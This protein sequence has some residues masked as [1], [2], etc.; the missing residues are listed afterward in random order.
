MIG[1]GYPHGTR[2]APG[3]IAE[4]IVQA[5]L[6]RGWRQSDLAIRVGCSDGAVSLWEGDLVPRQWVHLAALVEL[7]GLDPADVLRMIANP[8]PDLVT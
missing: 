4:T 2:A 8:A 5:R 7:L 3:T 1:I 6:K